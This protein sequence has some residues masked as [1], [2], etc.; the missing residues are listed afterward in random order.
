MCI[1]EDPIYSVAWSADNDSVVFSSGKNLTIKSLSA[2]AKQ[3]SV[4]QW[5]RVCVPDFFRA[6]Y[7]NPC[8][9]VCV[10]VESTRRNCVEV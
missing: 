3:N 2:N 10:V 6:C 1:L 8:V 9:C 5:T 4:T 7:F